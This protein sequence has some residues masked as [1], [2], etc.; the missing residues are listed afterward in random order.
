MD[1]EEENSERTNGEVSY[2]QRFLYSFRNVCECDSLDVMT[3]NIGAA[4][5]PVV[6]G[7]IGKIDEPHKF[8]HSWPHTKCYWWRR[9]S[10]KDDTLIFN[11]YIVQFVVCRMVLGTVT[12][13]CMCGGW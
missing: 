1:A 7:C 12:R 9:L 6:S 11:Y 5:P 3:G 10:Q 13:V 2:F 8:W 4:I